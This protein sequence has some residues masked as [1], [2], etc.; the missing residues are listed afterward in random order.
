MTDLTPEQQARIQ[1]DL[2]STLAEA[3]DKRASHALAQALREVFGENEDRQR[4]I[5]VSRIPLI[6]KSIMDIHENIGDIKQMMKELPNQFVS[7]DKFEPVQKVVMGLVGL[8]LIAVAG[9]IISLVIP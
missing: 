3:A 7:K 8:C 6:C 4:F 9:A 2:A 1:A 5:D